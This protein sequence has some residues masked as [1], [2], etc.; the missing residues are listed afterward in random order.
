VSADR[1]KNHAADREK[2]IGLGKR[3]ISKSYYPELRKRLDELE[4][5]RALLDRVS[6][7]IF[8]VDADTGI[9][10]DVSGSTRAMLDCGASSLVG[11]PFKRLLPDHI[12]RH[13]DNLFHSETKKI[14]LET[15]LIC[16]DKKRD[17]IPV[18]ISLQLVT[19]RDKRRAIIVARDIS[20][21]KRSEEA[22]KKS[23]D[24][25]EIRV[26]E[27]T[28]EL[29]RANRAKSEFLSVVSHELRTPLTSLLG[30]A[31]VI[32]KRL[33]K[34]I[35]PLID[36]KDEKVIKAITQIGENMDIMAAEGDR[37]TAL[38]NDVLDLAKLEAN[39][40]EFKMAPVAPGE[41]IKRAV[42][43]TSSIIEDSGLIPLLDIEPD[44]PPIRGD[45]DRLIQVMVNLISNA[46]KF[47][48]QG[49]ITCRA[50]LVGDNVHISVSD[51]GVGI[52]PSKLDAIFEEFTQADE[53]LENRPRGT[54]LGLAI[55]RNIVFG[56]GGYIWVESEEQ[57]GSTF[58]FTLPVLQER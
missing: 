31:K 6:D 2:L 56:H 28:R 49:T 45:L 41:F 10:L 32:R 26:R 47:T 16:P 17:P 13:A 1:D 27:R 29:D 48:S 54:G 22:L 7:T 33:N 57:Q 4:R 25:L 11:T 43:A 37:L 38:I 44:L 23:H 19:H 21:R 46:V 15:E 24:L 58:I 3:S 40:V 14:R 30:F 8:V 35:F 53:S 52:P 36:T 50:R 20:E 42:L 5:F 51:T 9:V 55:C 18:D 34:T 39:K 12:S